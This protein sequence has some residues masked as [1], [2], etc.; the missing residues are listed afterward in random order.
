MPLPA[1]SLLEVVEE[2]LSVPAGDIVGFA[3]P[4]L[5]SYSEEPSFAPGAAGLTLLFRPDS[6]LSRAFVSPAP[7]FF[8]LGTAPV[9]EYMCTVPLSEEQA[10]KVDAGLKAMQ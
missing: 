3:A 7:A 2:V 6:P 5:E 4:L 9:S 8:D 10:M 1:I